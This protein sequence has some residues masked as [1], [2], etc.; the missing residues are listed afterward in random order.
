LLNYWVCHFPFSAIVSC[1]LYPSLFIPLL[2]SD[3]FNNVYKLHS[4]IFNFHW[5][6][7]IIS[8]SVIY[9]S[10]KLSL[11]CMQLSN[12]IEVCSSISAENNAVDQLKKIVHAE[13]DLEYNKTEMK[14]LEMFNM[15]NTHHATTGYK[16]LKLEW[17]K[18]GHL[19][20]QV[21]GA[22]SIF[23]ELFGHE[24]ENTFWLD[25][26]ST[27]KVFQC[28]QVEDIFYYLMLIMNNT[29]ICFHLDLQTVI[30][31]RHSISSY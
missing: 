11:A 6:S 22:E 7:N 14:H 19:A 3:P 18:F 10:S 5:P 13:R 15:V 20:G 31:E 28:F 27:E 4:F 16:C 9:P 25:S 29:Y 17:R 26:S 8:F 2:G 12:V 21:G 24:T 23:C 1:I 30:T